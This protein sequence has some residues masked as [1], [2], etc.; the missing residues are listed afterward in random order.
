MKKVYFTPG[1]AQLF[2]SVADHLQTALDEQIGSISHRSKQFRQLYQHADEQLRTLLNIPAGSGIFFTG[3]ATE[4]WERIITNCVEKES[5]HLVNGAFSKRFYEF[6]LDSNKQ[7]NKMEVVFGQG[8]NAKD[9]FVPVG[10]ELVCVTHN[11]TSSGVSMPA[12]EIHALKKAHPEKLFVV[13][14]VSSAPYP[15]LDL[16]LIDS[17][18][19]SVQKAFGMPAGLGIWIAN[20]KCL[21][22]AEE[23]KSK[24]ISIGAHHNLPTLFKNYKNF[25]TPA[26]P[27]VIG[28]YLLGKIAEEMNRKGVAAIRRET[29]ERAKALYAAVEKSSMLDIFVQNPAHRSPTVVVANTRKAPAEVMDQLKATGNIIGG[30]YGTY[31]DKQ[32]RI[33]NFPANTPEEVEKLIV[34]LEKL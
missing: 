6:S 31:K 28:I 9:V 7:A 5:F 14:A 18:F 13:D 22:K 24:G 2:P 33:A 8:F 16:S 26:T 19:F 1:P 12:E 27:N 17:M 20:E 23:L 11:E 4:I 29:D 15:N 3:S 25:E 30:G 34:E 21:A 32:V 10:A